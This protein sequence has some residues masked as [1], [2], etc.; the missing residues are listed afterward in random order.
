MAD[1]LTNDQVTAALSDLP[2]WEHAGDMI[3]K[4]FQFDSYVGGL[5]F[6]TAAGTICEGMDHHPD[7]LITWRKVKVSF[8]T[9]DAGSKVTQK[10]INAAAALE[11][12][13]YPKS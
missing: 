6:A 13:G 2:G 9:H 11:A 5:A 3:H 8:T 7:M 1:A 12:I 4:T 10:D